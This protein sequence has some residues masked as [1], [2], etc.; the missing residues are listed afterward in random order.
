MR[1]TRR[2]PRF[3]CDRECHTPSTFG[4]ERVALAHCL[5]STRL[6]RRHLHR[7]PASK[8]SHKG[9]LPPPATARPHRL[10]AHCIPIARSSP[11]ASCPPRTLHILLVD[12]VT[13]PSA[14]MPAHATASLPP[15]PLPHAPPSHALPPAAASPSRKRSALTAGLDSSN[16]AIFAEGYAARAHLRAPAAGGAAAGCYARAA[17][18]REAFKRLRT[19][20]EPCT[21][22]NRAD[23]TGQHA[24]KYKRRLVNNRR[25]AAAARVFQDVLVRELS[26]ALDASAARADALSAQ[27]GRAMAALARARPATPR[28]E[29]DHP[30]AS[31]DDPRARFDFAPP[32]SAAPPQ[33]AKREA[34]SPTAVAPTP[35]PL[36][37]PADALLL[38]TPFGS[39]PTASA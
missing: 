6:Q 11:P 28:G 18:A 12:N 30:L 8:S 20:C 10:I 34:G 35:A 37:H 24:R 9:R 38:E 7:R 26:H 17:D 14:D 32:G 31:F 33:S 29:Y 3:H 19:D 4:E 27:L 13:D 21:P 1:A 15:V 36:T 2:P 16:P 25:S 5:P 23:E 39:E 22:A